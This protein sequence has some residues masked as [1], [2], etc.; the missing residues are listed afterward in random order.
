MQILMTR[1]ALTAFTLLAIDLSAF[2]AVTPTFAP[3]VTLKGSTLQGWHTLGDA[4]WRA[5]DGEL[6]G[7]GEGWLVL[8]HS[9]Q[10]LGFFASFLADPGAKAGVLLRAEKTPEGGLKGVYVAL[11]EGELGT[12]SLVL[13]AKGRELGREKLRPV[14]GQIRIAPPPNGPPM[15][16]GGL[17]PV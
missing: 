11:S 13:D 17:S 7:T 12:Y 6:T 1:A 8:D 4:S 2:S 9:Y 10:D 5:K 15:Q 3:D 14:G 16:M